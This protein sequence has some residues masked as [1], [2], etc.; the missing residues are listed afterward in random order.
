MP[1]PNL[2][3]ERPV[4]R[5]DIAATFGC[6][7]GTE[8][9]KRCARFSSKIKFHLINQATKFNSSSTV[10]KQKASLIE[11]VIP[12]QTLSKSNGGCYQEGMCWS[13]LYT[14][15]LT[16]NFVLGDAGDKG[17]FDWVSIPAWQYNSFLAIKWTNLSPVYLGKIYSNDEGFSIPSGAMA[18]LWNSWPPLWTGLWNSFLSVGSEK[19]SKQLIK[20]P[21]EER[22]KVFSGPL[23]GKEMLG[24]SS[25]RGHREEE[26]KKDGDQ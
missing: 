24:K 14:A 6:V 13:V 3:L 4:Q 8:E 17:L 16:K 5:C 21:E 1:F 25:E 18:C 11:M 12:E 19:D 10:P 20:C 22:I 9:I 7:F 26:S 15:V 23:E 2:C